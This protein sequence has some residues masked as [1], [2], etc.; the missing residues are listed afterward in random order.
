MKRLTPIGLY[1][2]LATQTNVIKAEC[3]AI[4]PTQNGQTIYVTDGPFDITIPTGTGG[5]VK[6]TG[7]A[8]GTTT[9]SSSQWGH[10]SRG[11]ALTSMAAMDIKAET[12][13][14]VCIAEQLVT[15]PGLSS[16]GLLNG[17][18]NGLFDAAPVSFWTC[19]FPTKKYGYMGNGVEF[20]FSNGLIS[21]FTD[22]NRS[23]VEL[24]VADCNYYANQKVPSRIYKPACPWSVGDGNCGLSLAGTSVGGYHMT[25]VFT[26][27]STSTSYNLVPNTAFAQPAG[28]F[29]QGVVTC[30]IGN[31]A[32][33]SQTVKLH[34]S[35]SLTLD[36]PFLLPVATG[37]TFSVIVGCDHSQT[38]CLVKFANLINY[39]GTDYVPPSDAAL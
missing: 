29:T 23:R 3:F 18:L 10:W 31:N 5:F 12:W 8:M 15:M 13:S 24:E 30:T 9:F 17:I 38:A 22:I 27:K 32:G 14:L 34:A 11:G 36:N 1:N 7:A 2:W 39:G 21:K 20:M 33:L 37:D 28:Y 4:G 35:G 25:Q 19:W 6:S 16:I 26:A